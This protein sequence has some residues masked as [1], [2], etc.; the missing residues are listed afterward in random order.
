MECWPPSNFVPTASCSPQCNSMPES[1]PNK[2]SRSSRTHL[3]GPHR[4]ERED[5]AAHRKS[6]EAQLCFSHQELWP[7]YRNTTKFEL[8]NRWPGLILVELFF[9]LYKGHLFPVHSM[10]HFLPPTSHQ[11]CGQIN[12]ELRISEGV[13]WRTTCRMAFARCHCAIWKV[14]WVSDLWHIKAVLRGGCGERVCG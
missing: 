11:S 1:P 3:L 14:C 4:G 7:N 2:Y 8:A 13:H 9:S 12:G 5:E 6:W 10:L